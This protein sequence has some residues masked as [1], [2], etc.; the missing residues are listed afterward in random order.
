MKELVQ[1]N[2]KESARLIAD[3]AEKAGALI[4]AANIIAGAFSQEGS[5]YLFGNGGSAADAQHIAGEFVNRFKI[6]RPPLP[7]VALTVDTSVITSISNDYSYN[8]I[9]SKQLKALGRA[10]DVA[11]GFSTS[12]NSPNVV[13][14]LSA[15]RNMGLKT[16]C[17]T[18]DG[19]GECAQYSD[20]LLDVKSKDTP[21]IQQV[22]ITMS[23]IICG[24]VDYQLFQRPGEEAD[25]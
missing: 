22:H 9:F 19:G 24:L 7:A 23:H 18:G 13:A 1:R 12:G 17:M 25:L 20:I 14:A 16:I 5:L 10:G 21:M 4:D 11:W 15:A 6:E 8:E 2:I 3:T